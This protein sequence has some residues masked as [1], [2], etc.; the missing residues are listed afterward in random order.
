MKSITNIEPYLDKIKISIRDERIANNL[1]QKE[2]SDFVNV[3]YPTYR[4][5]EQDGKISLTNFLLILNGLN[6]LKE[7][8]QFLD[9]FEYKSGITNSR[10][11]KKEQKNSDILDPIVKPSQKHIVLDKSIFGNELFYSVDNGH[12]YDV[13]NFISIMLSNFNEKRIML[14]LKYFGEKRLKP[15]ILKE[16]NI[17]LLKMFNKHIAYIKKAL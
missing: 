13:S 9:G 3:K 5:F 16:K 8:E 2:F 15:Y 10:V 12:I 1:T 7:F 14:L 17:K 4:A 11:E 6:K